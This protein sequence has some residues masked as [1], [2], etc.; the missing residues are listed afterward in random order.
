MSRSLTDNN[1][2]D[3][4]HACRQQTY[5]NSSRNQIFRT[6]IYLLVEDQTKPFRKETFGQNIRFDVTRKRNLSPC[7]SCFFY[8]ICCL[9]IILFSSLPAAIGIT[10][11]EH[12]NFCSLI[13]KERERENEYRSK[14]EKKPHCCAV[15]PPLCFSVFFGSLM[16]TACAYMCE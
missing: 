2:F 13:E 1:Y 10:T 3:R 5:L 9:L 16:M 6:N 15:L 4:N 11:R 8:S 14:R 7:S 12:Y